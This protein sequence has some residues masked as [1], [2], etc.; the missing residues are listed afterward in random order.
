MWESI[1]NWYESQSK[2]LQLFL[3]LVAVILALALL[4]CMFG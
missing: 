2:A 3:A 4:G 1:K